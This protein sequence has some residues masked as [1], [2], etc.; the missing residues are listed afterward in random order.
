[1]CTQFWLALQER[2]VAMQALKIVSTSGQ[3]KTLDKLVLE[4]LQTRLRGEIILPEHDAYEK[5]RTV[6]NGMVNKR[7]AVIAQCA[8]TA[9]VIC[10]VKFARENELLIAIRGGGHNVAGNASCDRGFVIDLSKMKGIRVDSAAQTVRAQAGLTWGEFD[11]ETQCFGLATTGGFVP[12]TGI[13]GLT[14][15]GGLG[16]LGRRFGLTCDNLL[17]ADVVTAD[18]EMRV[19]NSSENKD[20][21]WGLRG[22]GGNFGLVTSF[23]YRLHP[24]GP[25][26]LG[27][28]ILHP[29]EKAHE[30]ARFYREFTST[31]PE[32]L[33]THFGFLT[34]PDGHPVVA[35]IVC[36]SG[37][38]K[39]GDNAIGP[40]RQFGSPLADTVQQMPYIA[41]QAMG[42]DLYP[43]GR[44]N[45]WKSSFIREIS[46]A[47]IE[48]MISY[49]S[50]V[51]SP[52][53]LV[54][55]EQLGGAIKRVDKDQSAFGDRAADYSLIITSAWT[56]TSE[57]EKNINWTRG[58]FNA[59]RPF[60]RD[61]VYVNYLDAGE[62]DR[63]KNAYG[64]DHY[65]RL[66]ALKNKYDPTN[67]FRMNQNIKPRSHV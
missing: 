48:T 2:S 45:Y 59:M 14:L 24:V 9:D 52:F 3:E 4:Q 27:G 58:L 28:L 31:S 51:S 40:L 47:A 67:F 12:S 1:M 23:K 41:L 29:A 35:F 30:A 55:L 62:E 63:V 44:L 54:A 25:V 17:S 22:G 16:Y 50:Q 20:L 43:S 6:W 33:T 57:N 61:S 13:A 19:A 38:L 60:S 21:F 7:P 32:E 66:V 65:E 64:A 46:D 53:S 18:G 34:S 26:V 15:G 10:C 11:R 42:G 37:D 36:Y 8:G 5:V 49:F 39:R 56:E